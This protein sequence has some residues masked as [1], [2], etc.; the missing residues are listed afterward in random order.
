MAGPKLSLDELQRLQAAEEADGEAD[1]EE[2]GVL[3]AEEIA[4]RKLAVKQA[5]EAELRALRS[6]AVQ[7]GLPRPIVVNSTTHGDGVAASG[8]EQLIQA[9]MIAMLQYDSH[10]HPLH[11]A[12]SAVPEYEMMSKDA[13][14]AARDML[15]E[16]LALVQLEHSDAALPGP[17]E[18]RTAWTTVFEKLMYLPSKRGYD[19]VANA[20]KRDQ[21]ESIEAM[22]EA[23]RTNLERDWKRAGRLE[24]KLDLTIKEH[25]AQA[26]AARDEI[27]RLYDAIRQ[28]QMELGAC[29]SL[30]ETEAVAV[31]GRVD[32]W[33]GMVRA[34]AE[35]EQALQA[36]YKELVERREALKT[37]QR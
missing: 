30:A 31:P 35:R 22:L 16:E 18:L 20:S 10:A 2:D 23:D 24:K 29:E 4:R 34:Q 28:A 1:G 13:L 11:G 32:R 7:R 26:C 21:Q 5:R 17:E 8:P 12:P 6:S 19:V 14:D 33:E 15:H 9:E 36:R 3:D 27:G 25:V 37:G